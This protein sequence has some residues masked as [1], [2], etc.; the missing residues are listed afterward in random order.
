[1]VSYR[2]QRYVPKTVLIFSSSFDNDFV[3]LEDFYIVFCENIY[4]IIVAELPGR[5]EI[6]GGKTVQNVAL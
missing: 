2:G 4:A 5:Y 3:V 6:S 1:M